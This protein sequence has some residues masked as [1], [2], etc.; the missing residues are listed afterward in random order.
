MVRVYPPAGGRIISL[1]VRPGDH[2]VRGQTLAVLESSDIAGARSDYTKAL[3][4]KERADRGLK[5]ASLLYEHQVLPEKEY[6]DAQTDA[7][8]AA[9]ELRRARERLRLL[10][11]SPEGYSAELRVTAPRSGVVFD[12]GAAPGELNKALDAQQPMCTVADLSHVWVG[13][14]VYEK[15]L[16]GLSKGS[17]VRVT[18]NA[19]PGR[20]WNGV[21]DAISDQVDPTTRTLKLRVVLPNPGLELK[22]E[23]FAQIHVVRGQHSAILLPQTAVLREGEK[24]SVFVE[25]APGKFDQRQVTLASAKGDKV[26]I[27][28]GLNPGDKVVIEGA[29]LL[30]GNNE[31]ENND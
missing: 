16:A 12:L 4:E 29:P 30:R 10:G 19:Y 13:G 24:A 28:S 8:T 21:V 20:T 31:D 17:P 23:M 22:P 3:A 6:L 2:V 9:S 7:A 26:E 14:D 5:R 25:Q 27:A 11:V 1:Q 18:V 15:D